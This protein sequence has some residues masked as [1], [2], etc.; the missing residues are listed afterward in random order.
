MTLV[1]FLKR[2]EYKILIFI[3]ITG[4]LPFVVYFFYLIINNSLDLFIEQITGRTELFQT[5]FITFFNR[6]LSSWL[7]PVHIIVIAG[8]IFMLFKH[9][10]SKSIF[11]ANIKPNYPLLFIRTYFVFYLLATV[12]LS[13]LLLI[14]PD[15]LFKCSFELFWIYLILS[16]TVIIFERPIL[17]KV[18]LIIFPL[19]LAWTSAIS[20]GDNV[21]VFTIGILGSSILGINFIFSKTIG[22]AG[23]IMPGR[24]FL[25]LLIP[26]IAIFLLAGIFGQRKFNYRDLPSRELSASLK[27]INSEFGD[28]KTN[29]ITYDYFNDLNLLI[30]QLGG[31]DNIRDKVVVLP[32]NAIFYPLYK[33]KN[34]FPLDW[35]QYEEYIGS[36]EYLYNKITYKLQNEIIF[37]IMD[38]FNS[39]FMA[40]ELND[41]IIGGE[42]YDYR[43][44]IDQNCEPVEIDSEYFYVLRSK[45]I[46]REKE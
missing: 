4:A 30:D 25:I 10:I 16:L 42:K 32:N 6:F 18:I 46:A 13:L 33:T 12:I 2:R 24:K 35:L 44:I 40:Y 1:N 17:Q 19:I 34:P 26:L 28:I 8:F 3:L 27:N 15:I 41:L 23:M 38:K 37:L 31:I 11:A 7:L 29:P 45:G 39:K 43:K 36:E 5:G 14:K 22:F 9:K 21:P 20:L